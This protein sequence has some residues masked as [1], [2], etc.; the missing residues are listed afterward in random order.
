MSQGKQIQRVECRSLVAGRDRQPYVHLVLMYTDGTEEIAG[1]MT[2]A[3]ARHH[4]MAT[5]EAA[6]A[7]ET[8]AFLVWFLEQ[9]VGLEQGAAAA[10]LPEFRTWREKCRGG[11]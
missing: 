11:A 6:E 9:R 3:E 1:Q 7:A 8:D 4:A 5:L 2:V 10:L